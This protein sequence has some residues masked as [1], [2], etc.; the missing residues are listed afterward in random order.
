MELIVPARPGALV[1]ALLSV[2]SLRSPGEPAELLL[3]GG[4]HLLNAT[5]QLGPAHSH[6]VLR[7]YPGERPVI[8]GGAVIEPSAW[9]PVTGSKTLLSATLPAGLVGG[10]PKQ[11]F[12]GN[13]TQ[14]AVRARH[15]NLY[16][17][18]GAVV[19]RPYLYWASE[20]VPCAH[21]HDKPPPACAQPNR[22]G[23]RWNASDD[24]VLLQAS[25]ALSG[26]VEAIVYH[27]WTAS[28]HQVDTVN[29]STRALGF[30]NPSDRPIGFWSGYSSEGGQR[31]YLENALAFIDQP[32]EF[33]V[34]ASETRAPR[35][36][37]WP[38]S[39]GQS[40]IGRTYLPMIEEL[41]AMRNV[42]DVRWEEVVFRHSD[43]SCGGA[44]PHTGERLPCDGQS[45]EWQD[46]AVVHMRDSARVQFSGCEVSHVGPAALWADEGCDDIVIS[47]CRFA[48]LG[49]GAIRVGHP[50][51]NTAFHPGRDWASMRP[52]RRVAVSN[53]NLTDGSNV[54]PG[55]TA[56][57]VQF[58]EAVNISHNEIARFSY[59]AVS[60]GWSWSY[61]SQAGC[62]NHTVAYNYIH[63]LG[64][65]RRETGDAMACVY[66]LGQ[67]IGSLVDHNVC[68]DV[69]AYMGG[70]YCLSQDQ[71][72]SHMRFT[73]NVCLRT[74]GSPH[75]THYG[76]DV[77]YRNN[78]FFNG[79]HDVW[80]A[81][82]S[83]GYPAALRTSPKL[84]TS[85]GCQAQDVDF[86]PD[87][88]PDVLR[89]VT[90]LVG[91]PNNSS[92][93]LFEGDWQP[94][95]PLPNAS[96]R[97]DFVNNLYWTDRPISIE[98]EAVFGGRS[99]RVSHGQPPLQL[100]WEEWRQSGQ[101]VNGV[102]GDPGFVHPL[103]GYPD[104]GFN[105]TLRADSLA[106][107]LGWKHIDTHRVGI[108]DIAVS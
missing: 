101:D 2:A 30:A 3:R 97:F 53:S 55:G 68:H 70:G 35:V 90:N 104:S 23:F 33:F 6:I 36:Y 42:S 93:L 49:T 99:S 22:F 57:L 58:A 98:S 45:V 9:E 5:L 24:Q 31:Y 12:T 76:V 100:S 67:N 26:G 61:K 105:V 18:A 11:M 94:S 13:G 28:R 66:T 20:L 29:L 14:R 43:W 88:C 25:A 83:D 44:E 4:D 27:G 72:S 59:T 16:N 7:A 52:V 87:V 73:N 108:L 41:V 47:R 71:G 84:G 46:T 37:Y 103:W 78:I 81:P 48:D 50:A 102:V 10:T 21:L 80:T 39:G 92:A 74:T 56:V 54:F 32:G 17:A 40:R 51:K 82:Y 96:I 64:Y 107:K 86:P 19:E 34:D 69:R 89:F 15:P 79:S 1:A 8:T 77:E 85:G 60:L 63:H 38:L 91:T 75:N 62:G 106:W 95:S 65:P